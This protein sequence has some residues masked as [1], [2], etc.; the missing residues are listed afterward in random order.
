MVRPPLTWADRAACGY[1]VVGS[2]SARACATVGMRSRSRSASFSRTA[3]AESLRLAR[4][5]MARARAV[6]P[7]IHVEFAATLAALDRP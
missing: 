5:A 7:W 6:H 1:L 2:Q 4:A 3:R